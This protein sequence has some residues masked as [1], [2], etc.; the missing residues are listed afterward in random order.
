MAAEDQAKALAAAADELLAIIQRALASGEQ[1][2]GAAG[3]L[4]DDRVRQRIDA[5]RAAVEA[6]RPAPARPFTKP[7][8]YAVRFF[9]DLAYWGD[10]WGGS[11]I[12]LDLVVNP[13]ETVRQAFQRVTGYNPIHIVHYEDA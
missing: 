12:F 10:E 13:G 2:A 3:S 4:T 11:G 8:A 1:S 6:S 5:I 9:Y 7:V